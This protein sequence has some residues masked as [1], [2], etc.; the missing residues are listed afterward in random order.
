[1]T[2][3]DQKPINHGRDHLCDGPDPIPG[4]CELYDLIGNYE[5]VV[6][7]E[8][9]TVWW[10]LGDT[11]TF[12]SS[13]ADAMLN[14]AD[15][16]ADDADRHLDYAEPSSS[17]R[18]TLHVAH[19]ELGAFDDGAVEFN[20][21]GSSSGGPYF[22]QS[23]A[24]LDAV[25]QF[26]TTGDLCQTVSL[27]V[28]V[29]AGGDA[30]Y[31]PV[32]GIWGMDGTGSDNVGWVVE[33]ELTTYAL[34]FRAKPTI[35]TTYTITG[36]TLT[37]DTWYHVAVTWDGTT[38]L[39]YVNG[40]FYDD[41]TGSSAPGTPSDLSDFA[42]GY[43][44]YDSGAT[45]TSNYFYGSVDDVALYRR[46]LTAAEISRIAEG[47]GGAAITEAVL[48]LA[49]SGDSGLT[50]HVTLSEGSNVTLTQSGQDIEI[51]A[52][53]GGGGGATVVDYTT[54]TGT[55][56]I[57]H[58]TS[59]TADTIVTASAFTPDGTTLHCIEFGTPNASSPASGGSQLLI[60]LF[61][62]STLVNTIAE[63]VTPA[64]SNTVVPVCVRRYLTPTNASHTYSIRAWVSSGTGS[65]L[66]GGAGPTRAPFYIRITT[67]S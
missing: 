52:A 37:V 62:G 8:D 1:M 27:W 20:K 36:P 41:T 24:E 28:K 13:V 35:G 29:K 58:T 57:T 7:N 40:A 42:I 16:D 31:G 56:S 61:D 18:P 32:C 34:R 38:W 66:G 25:A 17:N 14:T 39:L 47:G 30:I 48:S 9:L 46:V 2:R 26:G 3:I 63:I 23:N 49:K 44:K 45:S 33:V 59:G 65:V 50:G 22:F 4:I 55:V 60:A 15:F 19:S 53:S 43:A 10:R 6:R 11:F 21:T 12:G 5:D 54:G 64:A 51:A 67:G